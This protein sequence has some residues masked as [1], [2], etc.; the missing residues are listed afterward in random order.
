[1]YIDTNTIIRTAELLAAVGAIVGVIISVYK[2]YSQI[3]TQ[4]EKIAAIMAELTIIDYGLKGALEGLVE[5][6]ANGPCRDALAKLDGHLIKQAHGGNH[7][8]E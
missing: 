4:G 1:M 5:Q 8:T 6:G 2:I 3:K 7:E